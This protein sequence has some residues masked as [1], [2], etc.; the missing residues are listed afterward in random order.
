M[1]DIVILITSLNPNEKL[2]YLIEK[3]HKEKINNV[4]IINDGSNELCSKIFKKAEE[5]NC[6]VYTN[7]E[8]LGKGESLKIG[9][10]Y[11]KEN[12][13]NIK[14]IVTV[15]SD[16]QHTPKDIK[17]VGELLIKHDEI[18]LGCRDFKNKKVPL[19]SRIGN[20][21]SSFYFKI[22]TG[23]KLK[24][25]QTG[26]RGI[27]SKYFEIALNVEGSRY[28]YEMRF[29]ETIIRK[30]IDFRTVDIET[31]YEKNRITH[32][33]F[34]KDSYIIYKSFFRNAISAF[35]SAIIDISL[36]MILVKILVVENNIII[37]T[38]LA[39]IISGLYNFI[40]NKFWAFEKKKS[41]NTRSE[42]A[43]YLVLFFIQMIV[44]GQA[45]QIIEKLFSGKIGVVIIKM[46]VDL[47][48]F[49]VNFII[50]K[51]WIFKEKE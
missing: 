1:N 3:L 14:G 36:F 41:N 51:N 28:E 38:I 10:K 31:I 21:F 43:K 22:T 48:I 19:K 26:L 11:I 45:T 32:F 42:L 4:V 17:K 27:P 23:R 40:L 34:V 30:N 35:S 16:G 7:E 13:Q 29:L 33:R 15:D 37:A 25:T 8:N 24:D 5:M 20:I 18:I 39:R 49:I 44:S 9:I 6:K 46:I 2:L 50:Q 47:I 12:I